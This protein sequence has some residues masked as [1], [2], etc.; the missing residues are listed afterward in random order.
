[1]DVWMWRQANNK[2][3]R[4]ETDTTNGTIK[5]YNEDGD[6]ISD[7]DGLSKEVIDLIEKNFFDV[8]ATKV[9]KPTTSVPDDQFNP[10]YV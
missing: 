9:D 3:W 1:M 6:I 10:M 5:V 7:R 8:V 4:V 2:Y